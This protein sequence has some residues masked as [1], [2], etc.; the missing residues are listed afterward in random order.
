MYTNYFATS[1]NSS[2]NDV[3]QPYIEAFHKDDFFKS[4]IV[5]KAYI[6]DNKNEIFF[7]LCDDSLESER[8]FMRHAL[9]IWPSLLDPVY[10]ILLNQD[11]DASQSG[12]HVYNFCGNN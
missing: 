7:L 2:S 9:S 11:I 4:G 1:P 6:S 12:M 3:F 10:P 5:R 8:T